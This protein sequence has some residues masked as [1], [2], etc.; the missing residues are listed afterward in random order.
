MSFVLRNL[1]RGKVTSSVGSARS[2]VTTRV[3]NS[4]TASVNPSSGSFSSKMIASIS[5][6]GRIFTRQANVYVYNRLR[7]ANRIYT[8]YHTAYGKEFFGAFMTN[9]VRR[10][11]RR[12][13]AG[14][15]IL[16]AAV[17]NFKQEG[18]GDDEV[19]KCVAEFEILKGLTPQ[20]SRATSHVKCVCA[21]KEL[22]H[23]EFEAHLTHEGYT[24]VVQSDK[25]HIWR[26]SEDGSGNYKYKVYGTFTD[27]P[28]RAF[29]A[30]Q[31]DTEYRKKWDKLVVNL[32]IVDKD[33]K[34][35][36]IHWH[37]HYPFPMNSRDYVFIRRCMV[38]PE[39]GVMVLV[40]HATDHPKCPEQKGIVR[41]SQ[42]E[43]N[44]VISPHRSFDENGFDY[45]LTYYDDP[46]SSF[47]SP[48]YAWMAASG[49]HDYLDKLHR[50]TKV[51]H[52]GSGANCAAEARSSL[53]GS[54][55]TSPVQYKPSYA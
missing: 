17:F 37:M 8:L 19:Q 6:L 38:D 11:N 10:M 52:E 21:P 39:S 44:M 53:Q 18:I 22:K 47:P 54:V 3:Q 31:C 23:V 42:Y 25:L 7:R 1:T 30:V 15:S 16:C 12:R 2:V 27:I 36:V 33:D 48:V 40:S 46:H 35:E 49:V 45:L 14:L 41:V 13:T 50:A 55:H 5:L 29:F 26:K 9:M 24:P 43:S 4:F 20:R 51:F 28:A 34:N 32:D